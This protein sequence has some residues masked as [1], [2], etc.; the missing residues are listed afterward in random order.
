MIPEP[1]GRTLEATGYLMNGEP[2]GA[3]C[4]AGWLPTRRKA[5]LARAFGFLPFES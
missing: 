3:Q 5:V 4:E 1:L 2:C